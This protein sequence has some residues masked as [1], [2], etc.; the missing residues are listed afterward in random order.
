[1]KI[2]FGLGNFGKQYEKSNHNVGFMVVDKTLEKLK[3]SKSQKACDGEIYETNID[4]N[5]V[6][7]V[8]PTTYMNN[9]GICV[10]SVISKYGA[11]VQDC[12]VVV[13]DI[14]LPAGAIRIR[15]HGSAGTHNGLRS[16]V[17]YIGEDFARVRVGIGK[18]H[19]QQ[20]LNDFVMQNVPKTTEFQNALEKASQAVLEYVQ[21]A[22]LEN[23][24]Q[25]Y[26]G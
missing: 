6:L 20:P 3:L 25:K 1:M 4:G 13:D 5:K 7:F 16:I 12:I 23:I 14:D 22:S 10:L 11:S 21:G 17:S 15:P 9:S 24:M 2:I 18:P 26:N 19:E 8:K